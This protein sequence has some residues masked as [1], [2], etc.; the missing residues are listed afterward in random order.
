MIYRNKNFLYDRILLPGGSSG[1]NKKYGYAAAGYKIYQIA[2][3]MNDNNEYFPIWGTCLGFELLTFI[4]A[5]R[6]KH[7]KKC[8]SENQPL[9]LEFTP[10]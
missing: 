8:D 4:D 5:E 7:R 2:K 1:F 9:P 6:V 3:Q 10:G